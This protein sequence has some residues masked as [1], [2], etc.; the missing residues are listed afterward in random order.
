MRVELG[1]ACINTKLGGFKSYTLRHLKENP[2]EIIARIRYNFRH[3]VNIIINNCERNIKLYRLTSELVPL[4]THVEFKEWE[5][6]VGWS[7]KE[8]KD[9][10]Q[11]LEW[12]KLLNQDQNL[13]LTLHPGQY[14]VLNSPKKEIHEKAVE[15][16]EYH[17]WVLNKIGGEFLVIHL[18]GVYGNKE[19]SKQRFISKFNT[20]S[21]D[22]QDI[23]VIENDDKSYGVKDI[24]EVS[25]EIGCLPLI[26]FHHHRCNPSKF[27]LNEVVRL[28]KDKKRNIKVHLSSGKAFEKDRR[29][30]DFVD[31]E[32]FQWVISEYNKTNYSDTLWLML[33]CKEKD[34]CIDKLKLT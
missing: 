5:K 18:G 27:D 11:Y 23:L 7:W 15:D 22:L 20:L 8:D 6:Q 30:S 28:W 29:H 19:A 10:L 9:I 17:Q 13:H 34:K 14:T 26:D 24:I 12:I 32:D 33:E 25:K 31:V 21:K 4:A 1:Y 16:L 2:L 3:T